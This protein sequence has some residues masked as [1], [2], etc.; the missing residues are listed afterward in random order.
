MKVFNNNISS[1]GEKINFVDD[2]NVLVGFDYSGQCC[3][4]FGWALS[5][6]WPLRLQPEPGENGLKPEGYNFDT[7]FINHE[8][9]EDDKS[10]GEGN[11][12]T[13]K[14]EKENEKPIFLTLWNIHNGY[15][16]HGFE[17]VQGNLISVGETK[18]HSGSL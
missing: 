13:F 6:R 4:S 18:I 14:L 12:V 9:P 5:R 2:N 11:Y 3:E 17:M 8:V 15:Y 10:Y 16:S 1:W 7:S